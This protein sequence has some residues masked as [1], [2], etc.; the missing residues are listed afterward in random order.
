[1]RALFHCRT[2]IGLTAESSGGLLETLVKSIDSCLAKYN[3]P[4][5]YKVCKLLLIRNDLTSIVL[6][7]AATV[8]AVFFLYSLTENS[9]ECEFG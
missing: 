4:K 1:M 7:T 2:F 5:F 6:T 9:T 3:L 8:A